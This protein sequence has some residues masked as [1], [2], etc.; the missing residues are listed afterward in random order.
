MPLSTSSFTSAAG[1]TETPLE[2]PTFG[3]ALVFAGRALRL[4]CPN[5]GQG[6]VLGN[7]GKVLPRCSECNYRY[8]RSGP[9]Y[10]TGAMFCNFLIAE[11]LFATGF[12]AVVLTTWPDVPWDA[13]TW[14]AAAGA[15]LVPTLLYP[16][17]KVA[18]L[19]IDTLVRPAM[20]DEFMGD[21][22]SIGSV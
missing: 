12:A 13:L 17:S 9:G 8:E 14:V 11:F 20:P 16:F 18:W 7:W 1:T 2:M 4:R 6:K 10:F 15:V 21:A 19:T 5:C 22:A 3:R